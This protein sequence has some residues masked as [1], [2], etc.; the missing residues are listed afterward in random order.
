MYE[1]IAKILEFRAT[2]GGTNH[3]KKINDHLALGWII[4]AIHERGYDDTSI[5]EGAQSFS[6]YILGHKDVDGQT[7]V[8]PVVRYD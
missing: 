7:P 3:V 4:L 6:F 2:H 1:G 5:G 8:V